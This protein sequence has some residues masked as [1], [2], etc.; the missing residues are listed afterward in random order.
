MESYD[1]ICVP[2]TA[3]TA[4]E[5]ENID[6]IYDVIQE[7]NPVESKKL[8]KPPPPEPEP[9]RNPYLTEGQGDSSVT[10]SDEEN[11]EETYD[12]VHEQHIVNRKELRKPL[13]PEPPRHPRLSEIQPDSSSRDSFS[14]DE[15]DAIYDVLVQ[16]PVAQL[17]RKPRP[18]DPKPEEPEEEYS[19]LKEYQQDVEPEEEY[20]NLATLQSQNKIVE[21]PEE[22]YSNLITVDTN[23]RT[24]PKPPLLQRS[25]KQAVVDKQKDDE[26]EAYDCVVSASN[27]I[28]SRNEQPKG[29]LDLQKF[30]L[31]PAPPTILPR[32]A[33][34]RKK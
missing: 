6:E 30:K 13:P 22:E 10:A 20:C 34:L 2:D 28:S 32:P 18:P 23:K 21:Q 15:E 26:E 7:Q 33:Y 29:R 9:L 3:K 11:I 14:E 24:L 27:P 19:N 4:P 31:K 25:T 8:R 12:V 17:A 16:K 1:S 5:E